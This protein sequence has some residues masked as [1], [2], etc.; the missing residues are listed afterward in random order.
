MNNVDVSYLF[1][2]TTFAGDQAALDAE[3]DAFWANPP[4]RPPLTTRITCRVCD[5]PAEIPILS[6]G[7]LCSLCRAD[8]DATEVHIR[9]TLQAAEEALS[10]A[11]TRWDADLAHASDDDRAWWSKVSAAAL[12]VEQG[13]MSR[14]EYDRKAKS[15][16]NLEPAALALKQGTMSQAE[17]DQ[18]ARRAALLQQ[19]EAVEALVRA[20]ERWARALAEVEAARDDK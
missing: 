20:T 12:A 9:G 5:R 10:D 16:L 3:V 17:Y 6:S 8:L 7:L 13:A 11:W 15:A 4:A 14:A 18:K 1:E 2:Q 19:S